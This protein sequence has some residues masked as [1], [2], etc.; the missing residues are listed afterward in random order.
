MT[1]QLRGTFAKRRE[2]SERVLSL[3]ERPWLRS[4]LS[5][6]DGDSWAVI[7]YWRTYEGVYV[8]VPSKDYNPTSP[9]TIL[10]ALAVVKRPGK[11]VK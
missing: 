11:F 2:T 7:E 5:E 3:L 8:I 9:L 4:K 1:Q 10:N 6:P